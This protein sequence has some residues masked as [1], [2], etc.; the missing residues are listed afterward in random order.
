MTGVQ[1]AGA[2]LA[3]GADRY[4]GL[5]AH[6]AG[7]APDQTIIDMA[8]SFASNTPAYG[9]DASPARIGEFVA[10]IANETGGFRKFE[11]DLR[12]RAQTLLRQWPSHFT[13]AQ[14][15]AAVGNPVEIASRAYGGRMGNAPYPSQDG[16]TYR[17][18]GAL[19]L[20]GRSAYR[21]FGGATGLPLEASPDLAADPADSV[22]IA[23]EFF[24]EEHVNAAID[25]GDFTLARRLTN[26]GSIGLENVAHLR[27]IALAYLNADTVAPADKPVLHVGAHGD[28][29]VAL[30]T[31]LGIPAD[32][33]FGRGTE[34]AV[35]A[36]QQT[37][38]LVDDGIVG[39]GTWAKLDG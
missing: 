34:T 3:S 19:Q 15:A 39:A 2:V 9:Q 22:L 5:F 10:Q 27:G 30:Q 24:K 12:Y 20:T 26:G 38:G 17:G 37:H 21:Q 4:V 11:E 16:Y 32:G 25:R 36:F 6:V 18:R 8:H 14:A 1:A 13:P 7:R 29:V 31:K 23:L 35:K 33:V 28:P